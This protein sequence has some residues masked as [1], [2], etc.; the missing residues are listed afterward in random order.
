MPNLIRPAVNAARETVVEIVELCDGYHALLVREF[1]HAMQS[2]EES[3]NQSEKKKQ[4][5]KIIERLTET[6]EVKMSNN[7]EN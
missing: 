1:L 5:K 4:I 7:R 3:V 2:V 6:V